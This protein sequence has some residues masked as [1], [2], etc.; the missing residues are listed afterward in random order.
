MEPMISTHGLTKRV[1]S[2]EGELTI[3]EDINLEIEVGE[4]LAVVGSSGSGKS[5]LLGLMAG[6]DLPSSGEVWLAG[7]ALGELDEDGRAALRAEHV[8]FVFQSFQLLDSLTALE[9]VMLPLELAGARKPRASAQAILSQVGLEA[10]VN[11]YPNQL[12]GGEQQRVAIARA[13]AS[14]PKVLFADEPT[15]NLDRRT[16]EQIAELLFE[17]NAHQR[18]TLVLVTHD[19]ALAGACKRQVELSG[20]KLV[21][22]AGS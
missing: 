22:G 6:L 1:P 18:T 12:S 7:K 16:G 10:R 13:F 15:G 11:H 14:H 4:T 8:G 21:N 5:T 9:N 2:P 3:L 17:I 19:P 20:G